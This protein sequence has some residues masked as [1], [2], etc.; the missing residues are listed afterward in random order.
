MTITFENENDVIV[1]ALEKIIRYARKNQY[2]IVAQSGWWIA[3]VIGLTDGL[4]THIDNLRIRFEEYQASLEIEQLSSERE[5]ASVLQD[6]LNIDTEGSRVHPDRISQINNTVN[7]SYEIESGESESDQATVIIKNAK[8]FLCKSRKERH[9]LKQK[10]CV[11][12]RT[13]SGK[14][15]VQPLT[16][17]QSN[18]LQAIPKDTLA[19]YL[20]SRK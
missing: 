7:D 11:L 4:V 12:S 16:K 5:V 20:E 18:R 8:E 14:I 9:A 19:T 10:P 6:H 3:S 15:P 1:Y 13:R 2:I 17:K